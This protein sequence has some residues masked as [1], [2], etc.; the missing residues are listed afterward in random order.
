[1][2]V[3]ISYKKQ[4]LYLVIFFALVLSGIEIIGHI[5][6]FPT[7]CEKRLLDSGIYE[8][9]STFFIIQICH[10]SES[11][12]VNRDNPVTY[13]EP[14]QHFPTFNSNN[15]GFRGPEI[16]KIKPENT[17]RIFTLGGSTMQSVYSTSDNTTIPGYLQQ[18]FDSLKKDYKVEV[19]NAGV[20]GDWSFQE[21]EKIKKKLLGFNPDLFIVYDGWNDVG[22]DNRDFKEVPLAYQSSIPFQK[23]GWY[24]VTPQIIRKAQVYLD[25]QATNFL[26]LDLMHNTPE[27]NLQKALLWKQ[28]WTEICK[29]GNE[30]GFDTI[31]TLQPILG[32]GNKTLTKFELSMKEKFSIPQEISSYPL[33]RQALS[34]LNGK[35]TKT[36]DLSHA[37]DNVSKTI[38]VDDGHIGDSGN[39]IIAQRLFALTEPIVEEKM[40][41]KKSH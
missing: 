35:C 13:F 38:Y 24:Y 19:I 26:G 22:S 28:R 1:M 37:L 7:S 34:E 8:N 11:T 21:S 15:Y 14:N 32:V 2:S 25:I 23:I 5:I 41:K 31:I 6:L 36:A 16:S 29:M 17:F 3:V 18:K 39:Y 27:D 12:V 40:E 33:M 30:N 10:D 4:I 9:Y 20:G